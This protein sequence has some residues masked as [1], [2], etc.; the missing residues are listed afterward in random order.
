MKLQF[1]VISIIIIFNIVFGCDPKTENCHEKNSRRPGDRKRGKRDPGSNLLEVSK[2]HGPYARFC[3]AMTIAYDLRY[4]IEKTIVPIA[5]ELMNLDEPTSNRLMSFD[6]NAIST[7]FDSLTLTLDATELELFGNKIK[8]IQQ[9][10]VNFNNKKPVSDVKEKQYDKVN[11]LVQSGTFKFTNADENYQKFKTALKNFKEDRT[12]QLKT[13]SSDDEQKVQQ[14]ANELGDKIKYFLGSCNAIVEDIKPT[15]KLEIDST[16]FNSLAAQAT[17]HNNFFDK[18]LS[19]WIGDNIFDQFERLLEHSTNRDN[20]IHSLNAIQ[21]LIEVA[22]KSGPLKSFNRTYARAFVPGSSTLETFEKELNG[23]KFKDLFESE[24]DLQSMRRGFK[25]LMEFGK[26]VTKSRPGIYEKAKDQTLKVHLNELLDHILKISADGLYSSSIG[27]VKKALKLQPT[28][29]TNFKPFIALTVQ[30]QTLK[31]AKEAHKKLVEELNKLQSEQE[32][33]DWTDNEQALEDLQQQLKVIKNPANYLAVLNNDVYKKISVEITDSETKFR[34]IIEAAREMKQKATDCKDL[35]TYVDPVEER[36]NADFKTFWLNLNDAPEKTL[37][38]IKLANDHL[39]LNM[40]GYKKTLTDF[41]S[42][43]IGEINSIKEKTESV[44]VPELKDA[45]DLWHQYAY[46]RLIEEKLIAGFLVFGYFH[47]ALSREAEILSFLQKKQSYLKMYLPEHAL[48]RTENMFE[49]LKALDQKIDSSKFTNTRELENWQLEISLTDCPEVV[50]ADWIEANNMLTRFSDVNQTMVAESLD[51]CK[52]IQDLNLDWAYHKIHAFSVIRGVDRLRNY[53][54]LVYKVKKIY[55]KPKVPMPK[56]TAHL[57]DPI[58]IIVLFIAVI[59]TAYVASRYTRYYNEKKY[60][61]ARR[62]FLAKKEEVVITNEIAAELKIKKE[63][64][65]SIK[66][67]YDYRAQVREIWHQNKADPKKVQARLYFRRLLEEARD[68]GTP[69]E[70]TIQRIAE[71]IQESYKEY[72]GPTRVQHEMG[73]YFLNTV[74]NMV[75]LPWRLYRI[76]R[77]N[78]PARHIWQFM[79]RRKFSILVDFQTLWYDD[80]QVELNTYVRGKPNQYV[81]FWSEEVPNPFKNVEMRLVVRTR[82]E[83]E[84]VYMR[85]QNFPVGFAP[86]EL[87][88]CQVIF[89]MIDEMRDEDGDDNVAV[90]CIDRDADSRSCIMPMID[91]MLHVMTYAESFDDFACIG[92]IMANQR[93]RSIDLVTTAQIEFCLYVCFKIINDES[94]AMK[95]P[96]FNEDKTEFMRQIEDAWASAWLRNYEK[97]EAHYQSQKMDRIYK[98]NDRDQHFYPQSKPHLDKMKEEVIRMMERRRDYVMSKGEPDPYTKET[99]KEADDRKKK[100]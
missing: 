39:G 84:M 77:N 88:P 86:F 48:D 17:F 69:I 15:S 65:N 54:H 96:M 100:Q 30:L 21:N 78:I 53:M 6:S 1:L 64:F 50:V 62:D 12:T 75:S 97:Y 44:P 19:H 61:Q 90:V 47:E 93:R 59:P 81:I 46:R 73:N 51:A 67:M 70:T 16:P 26:A 29:L 45:I 36:L 28:P 94:A 2:G 33:K 18:D 37:E 41:Q 57:L 23:P 89:E 80:Y 8:E 56:K 38:M 24:E 13:W 79:T 43:F 7:L 4:K 35:K 27:K 83:Y 22:E 92:E 63:D 11:Q 99:K 58:V 82:T 71:Q 31:A 76:M 9:F 14:L 60:G 52:K 32:F 68:K 95:Q 3:N 34:N 66:E 42:N 25:R 91:N 5:G 49:Q 98:P 20:V 85:Y 40:D 55:E 74:G 10:R 72:R 87:T